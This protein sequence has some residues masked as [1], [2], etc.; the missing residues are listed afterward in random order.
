MITR[1]AGN[2]EWEQVP[3][4]FFPPEI[5]DTEYIAPEPMGISADDMNQVFREITIE[6]ARGLMP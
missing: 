1:C 6:E 3:E 5:P 4:N 2:Y